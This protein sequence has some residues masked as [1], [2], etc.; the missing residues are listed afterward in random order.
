MRFDVLTLFVDMISDGL[1]HGV[2]GRAIER[3]LVELGVHD[4]RQWSTN[5]HRN[6]DDAPYGGGPGMVMG[7]QAIVA[8]LDA[9]GSER[10]VS[11]TILLSPSG[12]RFDQERAREL[13]ALPE[14]VVLVCGRYEGVDARV[15]DHF[16]DEELSLGDFVLSGGEVAAM[17]VIDAVARLIPGV[18]GNEDSPLEESLEGHLLEYPQ[19]TRPREFR[20]HEV[21][22]VLLSGNHAEIARWRREQAVQRTAERR[23]DLL[24]RQAL[25]KNGKKPLESA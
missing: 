16:C 12:R 2:T 9:L 14:A 21:P 6:V 18:L 19:Y 11:R 17:A 8:A 4:I 25:D 23:P 3:G 20:G 5:K 7:P 22:D 10:A 15:A 1:S 13:A 24:E